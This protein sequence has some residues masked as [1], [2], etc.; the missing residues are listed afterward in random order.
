MGRPR[1]L[2]DE[3]ITDMVTEIRSGNLTR[4][5]A[6]TKYGLSVQ[7]VTTYCNNWQTN[8]NTGNDAPTVG[9]PIGR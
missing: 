9:S 2:T 5:A 6:A 1:K 8:T 7:T 4:K 3:Q